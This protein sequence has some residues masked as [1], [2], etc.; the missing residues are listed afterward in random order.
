MNDDLDDREWAGMTDHIREPHRDPGR[1]WRTLPAGVCRGPMVA[2]T[3][4]LCGEP[5]VEVNR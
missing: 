1:C 2:G 4:T 5:K 3:C